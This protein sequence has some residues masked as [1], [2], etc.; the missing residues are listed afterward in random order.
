MYLLWHRTTR[1]TRISDNYAFKKRALIL[2]V[3]PMFNKSFT[4]I[5]YLML[6][7]QQVQEILFLD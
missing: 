4:P 7:S 6:K 3:S 1:N 5:N 2:N